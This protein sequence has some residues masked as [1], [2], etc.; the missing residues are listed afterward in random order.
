MIKFILSIAVLTIFAL[1]CFSQQT[2]E[3]SIFFARITNIDTTYYAYHVKG[4]M[5]RVDELDKNKVI[6]N[7]LLVDIKNQKLTAM[8]P[9]RKLYMKMHVNPYNPEPDKNFEIIKTDNKKNILGYECEQWRVKN[10]AQNTEI[11]YW[12]ADNNFCFFSDLLKLLNR[13][14]KQAK[15]FLQIPGTKCLGPPLSEERTLLRSQRMKLSVIDIKKSK[16]DN[17]VFQIPPDYKNFER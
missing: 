17:S 1:Q 8:S 10:K 2:F 9:A 7:S 4:D 3:G 6:M 11:S 12:V 13:S 14:E 16:L 5:V 15:F